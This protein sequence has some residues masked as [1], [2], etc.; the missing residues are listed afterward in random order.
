MTPTATPNFQSSMPEG[1]QF[2]G[3]GIAKDNEFELLDGKLFKGPR[4]TSTAQVLV[5]PAPGFLFQPQEFFDI[6]E[7]K[8]KPGPANQFMVVAKVNP[9]PTNLTVTAK[10]AVSNQF[11]R[12]TVVDIVG[13][14]KALPG[15]VSLTEG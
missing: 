15:F 1:V 9:E 13:K 3:I 5:Q 4:A 7:F 14:L 10:F 8:M 11:E 2:V 12:D 6:R